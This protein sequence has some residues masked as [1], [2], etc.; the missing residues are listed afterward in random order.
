MIRFSKNVCSLAFV[1]DPAQSCAAGTI[2]C[3]N[4]NRCDAAGC[5]GTPS[6]IN[7][8]QLITSSTTAT[9]TG[10]APT[11]SSSPDVCAT[12]A[13]NDII[14]QTSTSFDICWNGSMNILL[15]F[16]T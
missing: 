4:L 2:C 3:Q 11:Q 8:N 14:C 9:V 7:N 6:P 16:I 15:F 12:H 10:S 13:D 1:S 5:V